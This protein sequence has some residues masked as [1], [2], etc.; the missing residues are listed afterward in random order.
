MSTLITHMIAREI[1]DSRGNPTVEVDVV[2]RGG[3]Q[4]R[5]MVPSGASTG[6]HEAVELRD[7]DA[8]RYLGKGVTKAVAHVNTVIKEALQGRDAADQIAI[9]Q[10]LLNLDGTS[11]KG[12]LGANAILGV[13]LACARACSAAY[14]MPLFRY[15][16]GVGAC[17]LPVPLM[18][19]VNGGSHADNTLDIQE[20]MVM[21][22]G[23]PSFAEGLRWGAEIF[24]RLKT[25]LK[26]DGKHTAVGDEGGFAPDLGRNED[27][28]AYIL[29]AIE[30]AGLQP[31]SDVTLALDVAASEFYD[32][33]RGLYVLAG[34]DRQL[35]SDTWVE[36]LAD[37]ASRFPIAS[38]EDGC[39][40]NDWEA[41]GS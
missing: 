5:A 2:L 7:G 3:A 12:R 19:I 11:N 21:P 20:F 8:D 15:L 35:P 37:L 25:R 27:A 4:G 13:S 24:H 17:R 23:A 30:D 40:E 31:G 16:G 39:D 29:M 6:E 18:N 33:E 9:D 26:R 14:G 10:T 34:E 41:W 38:I 32:A 22:S 36:Y 28:L 1:L